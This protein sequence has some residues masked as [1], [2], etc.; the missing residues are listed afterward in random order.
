MSISH[1]PSL[2][3]GFSC[4]PT[5]DGV[6]LW[7]WDVITFAQQA[8]S[9]QHNWHQTANYKRRVELWSFPFFLL[10]WC[11]LLDSPG[12]ENVEVLGGGAILSFIHGS[13]TYLCFC[14]SACGRYFR[15]RLKGKALTL[16][17]LPGWWRFA[18]LLRV[19]REDRYHLILT[20]C[21]FYIYIFVQIQ[22]M[23]YHVF[24]SEL[25]WLACLYLFIYLPLDGAR[26]AFTLYA[27]LT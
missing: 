22:Q 4:G 25:Y 24:S 9:N 7:W 3:S 14:F 20:Y 10:F 17:L 13:I 23:R 27:K 2:I 12:P 21:R 1:Y 8:L 19:R 26:L 6:W 16:V 5:P 18:L 15:G 11:L